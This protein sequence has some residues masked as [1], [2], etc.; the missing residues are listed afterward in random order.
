MRREAKWL[1][2]SLTQT[3]SSWPPSPPSCHPHAAP[4]RHL[5]S[6]I[7]AQL[8]SE[9]TLS[10]FGTKTLCTRLAMMGDIDDIAHEPPFIFPSS[11]CFYTE[12]NS[13]HPLRR[14]KERQRCGMNLSE[15]EF[16]SE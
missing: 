14:K 8:L 1:P 4:G 16:D 7:P 9:D 12:R 2:T 10:P 13:A 15:G 6:G 3:S 5:R 11:L